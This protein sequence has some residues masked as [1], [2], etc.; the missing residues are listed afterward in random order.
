MAY[1]NATTEYVGYPDNTSVKGADVL[2][3]GENDTIP[4]DSSVLIKDKRHHAV[5]GKNSSTGDLETA[6][7]Y[8]FSDA[9]NPPLYNHNEVLE[10][11][12]INNNQT[13]GE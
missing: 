4:A 12:G 6:V 5:I 1:I 8:N 11:Y 9:S 2:L 10:A 13:P 3:V 7:Y